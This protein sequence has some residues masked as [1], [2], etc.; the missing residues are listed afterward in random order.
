MDVAADKMA[1]GRSFWLSVCQDLLYHPSIP[2]LKPWVLE[3]GGT[4][5]TS[6]GVLGQLPT[7]CLWVSHAPSC[8]DL[9]VGLDEEE[10]IGC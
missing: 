6:V 1:Q 4:K 9:P 7:I 5:R 3:I 10:V 8:L 2:V